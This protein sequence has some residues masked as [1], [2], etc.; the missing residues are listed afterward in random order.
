MAKL[1]VPKGADITT[2]LSEE[3]ADVWRKIGPGRRVEILL[4]NIFEELQRM[5]DATDTR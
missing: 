5:N 3:D 1:R 2:V 4:L